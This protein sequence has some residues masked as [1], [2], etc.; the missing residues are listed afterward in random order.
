[1]FD[2]VLNVSASFPG[3]LYI[4]LG[5]EVSQ[6]KNGTIKE[7]IFANVRWN[8]AKQ[9]IVFIK[10]SHCI[11]SLNKEIK[12]LIFLFTSV[13]KVRSKHFL[14]NKGPSYLF[15]KFNWKF[16]IIHEFLKLANQ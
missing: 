15:Q 1:M 16:R 13:L 10:E 14:L 6:E 7:W 12:W 2:W 8:F 9:T 3:A 11:I 5:K 4:L